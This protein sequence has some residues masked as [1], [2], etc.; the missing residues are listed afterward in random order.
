[1]ALQQLRDLYIAQRHLLLDDDNFDPDPLN[2]LVDNLTDEDWRA[3]SVDCPFPFCNICGNWG[4]TTMQANHGS[5]SG[6]DFCG[7]NHLIHQC[8]RRWVMDTRWKQAYNMGTEVTKPQIFGVNFVGPDEETD[9]EVEE[10]K[11]AEEKKSAFRKGVAALNDAKWFGESDTFFLSKDIGEVFVSWWQWLTIFLF[12][13]IA[14]GLCYFTGNL[15]VELCRANEQAEFSLSVNIRAQST[16]M[17]GLF[18]RVPPVYR[19]QSCYSQWLWSLSGVI[20]ASVLIWYVWA[21]FRKKTRRFDSYEWSKNVRNPVIDSRHSDYLSGPMTYHQN[22]AVFYLRTN[23]IYKDMSDVCCCRTS[24]QDTVLTIRHVSC[25]LY[26]LLKA[27]FPYFPRVRDPVLL[28]DEAKK[29]REKA[30]TESTINIDDMETEWSIRADTA[31]FFID[32]AIY[33]ASN[34]G[35]VPRVTQDGVSLPTSFR[36]APLHQSL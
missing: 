5:T 22:V 29:I 15:A 27:K 20:P 17:E 32:R 25:S 26:N 14:A 21:I 6:C 4:H 11:E 12:T 28:E 24:H 19:I 13:V 9:E 10:K 7:K 30:R 35:T 18:G 1:M 23:Q 34:E 8:E 2:Q 36:L 33:R 31:E 16:F 3:L